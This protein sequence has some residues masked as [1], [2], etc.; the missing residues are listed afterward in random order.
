[1][2]PT[3]TL[4][5]K[6]DTA[7]AQAIHSL[8]LDFNNQTSGYAFDGRA[9]VVTVADP[10]TR[11]IIGGLWGSTAYGFLHVDMLIVPA[12]LRRRGIGT[13]V[14]LQA[15][16]EAVRRGCHGA[17]LETFDFQA[18]GFYEKLGYSVFGQLDNTPPGH[19]RFF[20]RKS[21]A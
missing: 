1:V 6:P 13:R 2:T 12:N 3:I 21:L 14:M 11:E 5:E 8:L 10:A 16:E 19:I 4:L 15:E 20:L 18:R 7:A 17:Y 9:V